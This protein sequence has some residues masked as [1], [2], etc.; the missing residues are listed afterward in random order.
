MVG[1]R[2]DAGCGFSDAVNCAEFEGVSPG[3]G[4]VIFGAGAHEDEAGFAGSDHLT[5]GHEGVVSRMVSG[6]GA[7]SGTDAS[8]GDLEVDA[9]GVT[10]VSKLLHVHRGI[11]SRMPIF[12]RTCLPPTNTE[13]TSAPSN[14]ASIN[15]EFA[16][17]SS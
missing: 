16:C 9:L 13:A 11:F 14:P 2:V 12:L 4:F 5:G 10:D 17:L 8:I 1:D 15:R 3:V 7:D 6:F